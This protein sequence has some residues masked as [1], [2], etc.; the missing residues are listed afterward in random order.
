MSDIEDS[1]IKFVKQQKKE[2]WD[3]Y[4]AP[5]KAEL[6]QAINLF[7]VIKNKVNIPEIDEWIK[8]LNQSAN[9]GVFRRDFLSKARV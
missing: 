1:A 4:Q 9:L 2:A 7:D 8:D 5:I 6:K 3:E